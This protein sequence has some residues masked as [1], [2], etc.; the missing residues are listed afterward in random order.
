[1][2]VADDDG[3]EGQGGEEGRA[4]VLGSGVHDQDAV[5]A[6]LGPPAPVGRALGVQVLHDLEEEGDAPGGEGLLDA[7][8]QLEE[9]GLD[10]EGAGGAGEDEADAAGAFAGQGTGGA[11]GLPA[12]FLGD[13]ADAGSGGG[14]DAVAVVEGEGDGRGGDAGAFGDVLHGRAAARRCRG[15]AWGVVRGRG[16]GGHVVR[17]L[18]RS[19]RSPWCG[20]LGGPCG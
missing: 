15:D 12:Q 6:A 20:G 14:G 8:D 17:Q 13:L 2:G 18:L 4:G 11:V 19:A 7:G 9:E 16:A 1:M 3:R 10:A 5:H